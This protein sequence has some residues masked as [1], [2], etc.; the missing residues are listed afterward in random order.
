MNY[1]IK[2]SAVILSFLFVGLI[3]SSPLSEQVAFLLAVLIIIAIIYSIIQRKKSTYNLLFS[4]KPG[5]IFF[6]SSITLLMIEITGGVTSSLYFLNYFL[7]FGLPLISTPITSLI[8]TASFILFYVPDLI[9]D[10]NTDIFLKLGSILLLLPLSYF[11]TNEIYKRQIENEKLKE[12]VKTI[13]EDAQTL[14]VDE[15][16]PERRKKLDEIIES[17]ETIDSENE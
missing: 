2:Y 3:K 1:L 6:V 9:R 12:K 10:P 8:F 4:G 7:L 13:E 5:E 17:A 15:N 11:I 16:D 14:E